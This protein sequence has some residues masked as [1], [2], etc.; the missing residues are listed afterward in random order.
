M[1]E[2]LKK[3][4]SFDFVL[5]HTGPDRI[6]TAVFRDIMVHSEKYGDRVA[7]LNDHIDDRITCK[8]WWCGHW[9]MDRYHYDKAKGRGYQYLYRTVKVLSDDYDN[10]SI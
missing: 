2:L 9:H 6:N 10:Y 5:S 3:E 7:L 1:F 8:Q 4:N